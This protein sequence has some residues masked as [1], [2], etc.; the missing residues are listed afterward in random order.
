MQITTLTN[1]VVNEDTFIPPIRIL[2]T[3]FDVTAQGQAAAAR[4]TDPGAR[5]ACSFADLAFR[6]CGVPV[7]ALND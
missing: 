5:Q 7:A 2:E 3:D 6:E 4:Q 1:P